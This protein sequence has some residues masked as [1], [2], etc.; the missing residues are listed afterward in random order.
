MLFSF[1]QLSQTNSFQTRILI[2]FCTGFLCFFCIFFVTTAV[3]EENYNA[4]ALHF[5]NGN[6]LAAMSIWAPLAK[7]G[8]PAAQYSMGLLYDQGK[9]VD[10]DPKLA[11]QYF[12]LA[13]KQNLPAAQYYLGVKY[14]AGLGVDKNMNK[15]NKLL[16]LAAQQDHL[17]AQFQLGHFYNT[18][19]AGTQDPKQA[20]YWFTKAAQSGYGPAQH[21]LASLYLTGRGVTLNLREGVFWLQKAADQNDA[22]AMRDLG[23]LYFQGMGVKQDF[24]QAHD[25]LITPAED[26]SSLAQFLLAEIYA[27][28]GHGMTQNLQQAKKW[29]QLA[30]RSG[31]K[32]AKKRLLTI[33]AKKIEPQTRPVQLSQSSGSRLANDASR[34][35]QLDDSFY[36]LQILQ[37]HQ[38]ESISQ[39]TDQYSD[40]NTYFF[41]IDKGG[42]KLLFVLLYG[43][44]ENYNDAKK[45][46]TSLPRTFRLKTAPWIR[47]VQQIKPLIP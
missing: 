9:G 30:H 22:D 42:D 44:Y 38:Y 47:Q 28:G 7:Q 18:G 21:S 23:F 8:H 35:K 41:K 12:Q 34:F 29:Y 31:N 10:K 25:L 45:A 33:S 11:L 13:V 37:A 32:E 15:A 4:G 36:T 20:V 2:S 24:K 39:L 6:Y 3:A 19:E 17:Q 1:T 40:N 5:A 14:Y 26:G 16:T 27:S 46:A 43:H